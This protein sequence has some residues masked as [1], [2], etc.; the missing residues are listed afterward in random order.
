[1]RLKRRLEA[2]GPSPSFREL[3]VAAGVSLPTLQHYFGD[4]AG[5]LAAVFAAH[6]D[7][8]SAAGGPLEM[9]RS[10]D[11]PFARS[12]PALLEFIATGLRDAGLA[13]THTMGL[14]EGLRDVRAAGAYLHGAL[15]PTFAAVAHRLAA[16][17]ARGEMRSDITAAHA[18][19]ILVAPLLLAVLHQDA[20]GGRDH[21]P[22]D[23]TAFTASHSAGFVRAYRLDAD[24]EKVTA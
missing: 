14:A 13:A 23:L 16:H 3:A 15:D 19:V 11:L 17:Q 1:M 22:L 7:A 8:G 9:A 18:A 4:R 2:R 21:A 12:V 5:V 24:T 6:L 10:A 20:L